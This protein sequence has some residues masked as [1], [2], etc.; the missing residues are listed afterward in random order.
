MN[1]SYRL[2]IITALFVTCLITANIISVKM[3]SL[4][5]FIVFAG[6]FVFPLSYIVGDVLTE[7]YGYRAARRVIWLGFVCNLIFV[8]FAWVGQILPPPPFWEGQAAYESTLGAA[9]RLLL[10]SFCG[11]L[12]GEFANSFVLA[13]MKIL[14]RGRWL[15]GRTIG[16]TV[17]GQGLDTFVFAT[18]A[19]IGTPNFVPVVILHQWL[20]KVI[21]EAVFTPATYA[22][23]N[24]LKRKEGLDTYDYE[25]SYNPFAL[26]D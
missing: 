12:A 15:W 26:A 11:Y 23:V 18:L 10:A 22:A 16:S 20:V 6:V 7:V 25:T 4:G 24:Y 13:R 3:I 21:V 5:P 14:T 8:F 1:V 19:L 17:V 2:V 9:P